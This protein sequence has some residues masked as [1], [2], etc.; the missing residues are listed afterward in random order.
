M[1]VSFGLWQAV[2]FVWKKEL[3]PAHLHAYSL[4]SK[5]EKKLPLSYY[6][7]TSFLEEYQFALIVLFIINHVNG[8]SW[9]HELNVL[10]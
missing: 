6:A 4:W 1:V 5:S 8:I 9:L 2:W 10:L 7:D 3:K